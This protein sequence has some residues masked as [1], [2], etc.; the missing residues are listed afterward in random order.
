MSEAFR[1]YEFAVKKLNYM[2]D[3][4]CCLSHHV[5]F[6]SISTIESLFAL[7]ASVSTLTSM[8]QAMLIVNRSSQESFSANGTP[9]I[10]SKLQK[11][12]KE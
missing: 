2:G 1:L 7:F 10:K 12:R 4:Q 9:T 8:N 5:I 3:R 6:E 11:K